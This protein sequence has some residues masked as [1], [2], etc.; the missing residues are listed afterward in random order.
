MV[1]APVSRKRSATATADCRQIEWI[2]ATIFGIVPSLL[3]QAV[4]LEQ[5]L[6]EIIDDLAAELGLSV[7]VDDPELQLV[8]HSAHFGDEDAGR[9]QS[10]LTRTITGPL[11]E[12][13]FA[14]GIRSWHEPGYLAAEPAV[15]MAGRLCVPL[16]IENELLGFVWFID[17]G[18]LSAG[19][20]GRI[21]LASRHIAAQIHKANRGRMAQM[22]RVS[23]QLLQ[24]I[25]RETPRETADGQ[26]LR[27]AGNT[28]NLRILVL[29]LEGLSAADQPPSWGWLDPGM[30]RHALRRV[31]ARQATRTLHHAPVITE[32]DGALVIL[33]DSSWIA[34]AG[35]PLEM[36]IDIGKGFSTLAAA[37][38]PSMSPPQAAVGIGGV[39]SPSGIADSFD[40]AEAALDSRRRGEAAAIWDSMG[41]RGL[42]AQL[43][44]HEGNVASIPFHI[45]PRPVQGLVGLADP[46]L[47]S[48]VKL[49]LDLAGNV[50]R[51]AAAA[52]LHR[53]TVY[54]KLELFESRIGARLDSGDVRLMIHWW[55]L[56]RD[57]TA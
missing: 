5:S 38:L 4:A 57:M 36:A 30:S 51:T 26:S 24:L 29:R 3:T 12:H 1:F 55:M 11:R 56:H 13:V 52:H 47:E 19:Q 35:D 18:K 40:Q 33:G 32:H 2:N 53:T 50:S 43:S 46:E 22:A 34:A 45:L 31:V 10:L 7:A 25:R 15:A 49:Y 9:V 42:I 23:E 17:D 16:R 27:P 14:Q 20:L 6:Q 39:C 48:L 54:A 37:Q 44:K 28:P 41:A 8:A 21:G